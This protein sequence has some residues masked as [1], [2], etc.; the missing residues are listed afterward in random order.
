MSTVGK[1]ECEKL[2]DLVAEL[3]AAPDPTAAWTLLANTVKTNVA[4]VWDS[5]PRASSRACLRIRGSPPLR[6][7]SG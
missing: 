6:T 7:V 5:R 1:S 4:H 2:L 3:L